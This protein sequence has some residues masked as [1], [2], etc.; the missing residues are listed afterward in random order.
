MLYAHDVDRGALFSALRDA[1][2]RCA[3]SGYADEWD[4]LGWQRHECATKTNM[5]AAQANKRVEVLWTN[6][7]PP[8]RLL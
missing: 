6:Y 4:E 3:I 8:Q 5:G 2:S 7:D 1:K